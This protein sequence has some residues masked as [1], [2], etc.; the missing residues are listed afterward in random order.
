M[1]PEISVIVTNWNGVELLKKN[2]PQIIKTSSIASEIIV[3]D[4]ASTD[5]SIGYIKGLQ[6]TC[7]KLVLIAHRHNHGF[8]Y[9]SN[10]AVKSAKSEHVVLLNS[11]IYPHPG[12]IENCLPHLSGKKVFGVGF[13][14][15]GHE[16]YGKLFWNEGYLQHTAGESNKTHITGWLSGGSSIV[17]RQSFLKLEG[18]DPVYSPFYSEDLDLGYRAWKSG[19]KLLWEPKAIVEH[20]HE[21]TMSKFSSQFLN[22]VKE[23]NRLLTVL[24]NITEPKLLWQNKIAQVGRCLL[25]PNYIKIILAAHRQ[26]RQHR[27]PV[28]KP[29]LTDSQILHLFHE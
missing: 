23:R 14:E 25:G 10:H 17:H 2:L 28:V 1:K 19:Y 3:A 11:D 13:A 26:I 24:R 15:L 9:N 4:D 27:P 21:S 29:L 5:N 16:N 6:K 18:F 22:Y 7:S 8:G 20:N 12:Y